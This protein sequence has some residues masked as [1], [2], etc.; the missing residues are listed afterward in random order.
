[1]WLLALLQLADIGD[2][3][4]ELHSGKLS[5]I[6]HLR[7]RLEG[8]RVSHPCSKI[9]IVVWERVGAEHLPTSEMSQVGANGAAGNGSPD[10]VTH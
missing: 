6:G 2:E 9:G 5:K 4:A 7:F 8:L 3:V 10:G 1:M